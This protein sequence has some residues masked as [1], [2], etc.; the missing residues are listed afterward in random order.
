MT[1]IRNAENN[2]WESDAG[3]WICPGWAGR[4]IVCR[5]AQG[6][7]VQIHEPFE[8]LDAARYFAEG[9]GGVYY[10]TQGFA[11]KL[12][13]KVEQVGGGEYYLDGGEVKI[14]TRMTCVTDESY[15]GLV[16]KNI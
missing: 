8:S 13:G 1:W 4:F 3:Y 5:E 14:C 11:Y 16:R 10:D 2:R 6:V 7:G 9:F 15:P 12:T